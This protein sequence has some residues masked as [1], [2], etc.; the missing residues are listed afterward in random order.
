VKMGYISRKRRRRKGGLIIVFIAVVVLLGLVSTGRSLLK[1]Y[2][3]DKMKHEERMLR[4]G[5]SKQRDRLRLE[6]Y[7]LSNDSLY[8][9]GIA[10]REYGMIKKGEEVFNI[11]VPDTTN[12]KKNVPAKRK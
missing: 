3:L 11:S 6:V 12:G 7:R 8:I 10:R 2:R 5:L 4:D 9:E 1:I